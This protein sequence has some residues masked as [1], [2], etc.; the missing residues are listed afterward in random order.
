MGQDKAL[1]EIGGI[2]MLTRVCQA[3]LQCAESVYILTPWESRYRAIAP[4]ACHWLHESRSPNG[5]APGPL[6]AFAQSLDHLDTDWVLLLACDLPRINGA[7]LQQWRQQLTRTTATAVLPQ[8]KKGWE[9]L[10]GFYRRDCRDR[11]QTAIAQGTQSFQ[12][13]L[14]QESVQSLQMDDPTVLWNCNTP[15]DLSNLH[16]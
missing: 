15:E 14:A 3:A 16:R 1:I 5:A 11:L 8:G 10:C 6:V 4:A 13:W 2:P 7:V 9:P 12:Q